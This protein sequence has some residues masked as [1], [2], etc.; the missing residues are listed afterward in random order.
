MANRADVYVRNKLTG[1]NQGDIIVTRK[2]P[3]GSSDINVTIAYEAEEMVHLPAPEVSLLI[4]APQGVDT[5]ACPFKVKSDVDLSVAC[6]RTDSRWAINIV[7]NELDPITPTTV[8]V[9]L[10]ENEP[11]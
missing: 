9:D 11:E 7:A 1:V 8:N 10:G 2:L 3:D 4:N 6:S 5:R